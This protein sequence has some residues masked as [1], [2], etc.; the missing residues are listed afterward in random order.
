[1]FIFP[2]SPRFNYS[3][4]RFNES[5]SGLNQI[6]NLNRTKSFT[7]KFK[8]DTEK[9]LEELEKVG[10]DA[11]TEHKLDGGN[12]YGITNSQFAT[13][14]VIV[15]LLFVGFSFNFWLTDF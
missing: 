13:N 15:T 2:E 10:A 6:A 14:L 3:K 4:D 7:R 12:E 8:F 5:K 11:K 9:E 1:M